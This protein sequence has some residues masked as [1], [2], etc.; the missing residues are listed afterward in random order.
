MTAISR[1][2]VI[3]LMRAICRQRLWS[4]I[5]LAVCIGLFATSVHAQIQWDGDTST[6]WNTGDNWVGGVVPNG[7]DAA[8]DAIINVVGG[9]NPPFT[10]TITDNL[11]GNDATPRDIKV[12]FGAA[13]SGQLE[14]T[15]G[16][17]VTGGGSGLGWVFIGS[18]AGA[19]GTYNMSG[20]AT[21]NGGRL[22]IGDAGAT[23]TMN[24]S[25]SAV[26]SGFPSELW[27]GQFGAASV[28]TL[29][30]SD[31]ADVSSSNWIA[32]GRDSAT[33]TVNLSGN[34]KLRKTGGAGAHITLGGFGAGGGGTINIQDN[35]ELSSDTGLL[36]G[37][38]A[39]RFGTINQTGGSVLLTTTL[40]SGAGPADYNLG[41][42]L[43]K[44]AEVRGAAANTPFAGT[45]DWTG[46]TLSVGTFIGNLTQGGG[47]LM[48]GNS[49]GLTTVTGNYSLNSGDLDIELDGL[50]AQTEYDVLA[51]TGDVSLAGALSLSLGFPPAVG[52]S[53]TIID[54]Q[55][56]NPVSGMFTQGSSI[57]AGGYLF[58]I[59]YAG[60]SGNDVVLTVVPEPASIA[61]AG[62][63]AIGLLGVARRRQRIG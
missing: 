56:A 34:G 54:N 46:G 38:S 2:R 3:N 33:G 20:T 25:G 60:G 62:L 61:L 44:A 23:G 6:D 52:N 40:R 59:N 12:G 7:G 9:G 31:D 39:G 28:G 21:L 41:G 43:L 29:N 37:E 47:T 35:A 42:G 55:G 50:I 45:F 26:I 48:V 30:I 53:F 24:V 4:Q 1:A 11:V 51:V 19:A 15:S 10:A 36:M 27:V 17:A 22:L 8:N 63:A 16:A 18:G 57:S 58:S 5:T 14:H 32:V 13:T 49:P